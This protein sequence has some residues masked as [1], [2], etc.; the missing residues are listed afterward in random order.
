MDA[1]FNI[2]CRWHSGRAGFWQRNNGERSRIGAAIG[3]GI[4]GLG[5]IEENHL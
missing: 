1:V 4:G 3:S 5:L 2:D